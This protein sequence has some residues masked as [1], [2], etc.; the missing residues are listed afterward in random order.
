MHRFILLW[1]FLTS[2][3]NAYE[4][5]PTVC[6]N[7]IVKNES[8]V[9]E[10]CLRAAK[11]LID[12]WVIVDTGSTDGTQEI[13]KKFMKDIPG[14]LHERPWKNFGHNRNEA[15][16][17]AKNK[18]NY[19]LFI[20]ADEEFVIEPNFSFPP[21]TESFY[22]ITT[23]FGGTEY[24][25]NQLIKSDLDWKWV[26]V[27]HEV[28]CCPQATKGGHLLGV[29]DLVHTDGA[30]SQD[31]NK[32]LKDAALLEEAL[33][34]N[35][36]DTRNQFYLAQSYRDAG[37]SELALMHYQ[38]RVEMGGWDEEV[39][40]SMLQIARL[41]QVLQKDPEEIV[42]QYEKT[43]AFRPTRL[44]PLYDLAHFYR[45][46]ED[47]EKSYK[48]A[49]QG[50]SITM[51][52]QDILFIESWIYDWGLLMEFSVSS[53]WIEKYVESLLASQ[54]ILAKEN[55]HTD[56]KKCALNN[57]QWALKKIAEHR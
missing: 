25:R 20:D 55:L 9:I 43:F 5:R 37:K 45:M 4:A 23:Q 57:V 52:Q 35:P 12:Y 34:E 6:L 30:R 56:V 40:W 24:V 13:I 54:L 50:L 26:G 47:F 19:L 22:Y 41:L 10:R 38:K 51:P 15:L 32:Y 11:P 46:R 14:E 7:M 3:L 18:A 53:Y 27:L 36:N 31:P 2:Y 17:L 8:E 1:V 29:K 28:L 33:K 49:L 16:Q 39:F 44:E 48:T 21:L 42:A